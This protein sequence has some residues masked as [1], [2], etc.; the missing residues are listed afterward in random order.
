MLKMEKQETKRQHY[1]P[2]T[3]LNKF[4]TERKE[5]EFQ[6]FALSKLPP[7]K[8]VALISVSPKRGSTLT[9]FSFTFFFLLM[10]NVSQY[11]FLI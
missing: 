7:P 3:Y 1:V 6:V 4:G 2:E 10:T 11:H 8:E 9:L 5:K